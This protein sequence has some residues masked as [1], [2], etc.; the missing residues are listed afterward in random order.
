MEEV[1]TLPLIELSNQK[2]TSIN[3][4][5]ITLNDKGLV[6]D[7]SFFADEPVDE[8]DKQLG[9]ENVFNSFTIFAKKDRISGMEK[10]YIPASK[11]WKLIIVI[12]GFG[13]DIK[14]YFKRES[15]ATEL[16]DR[17]YNWL[18]S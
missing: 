7:V 11:C 17:I 15:Q 8:N 6:Y 16:Y 1:I 9:T 13:T 12:V 10:S 3:K 14:T 18:N 5:S 4:A 2:P